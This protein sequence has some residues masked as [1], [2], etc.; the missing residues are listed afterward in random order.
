MD[1][2]AICND[3]HNL[4]PIQYKMDAFNPGNGT[5]YF[6]NMPAHDEFVVE[7]TGDSGSFTLLPWSKDTCPI[8]CYTCDEDN[9]NQP[10]NCTENAVLSDEVTTAV[11]MAIHALHGNSKNPDIMN[12]KEIYQKALSNTYPKYVKGYMSTPRIKGSKKGTEYVICKKKCADETE[13]PLR[14]KEDILNAIGGIKNLK[15]ENFDKEKAMEEL[16]G[17][18][19]SLRDMEKDE[20]GNVSVLSRPIGE[21]LIGLTLLMRKTQDDHKSWR[22]NANYN[23]S[24]MISNLT[25][26]M[27][28]FLNEHSLDGHFFLPYDVNEDPDVVDED[29]ELFIHDMERVYNILT[30]HPKSNLLAIKFYKLTA[31]ENLQGTGLDLSKIFNIRIVDDSMVI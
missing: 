16:K 3:F 7:Y 12:S 14:S 28:N 19:V 13:T 5:V 25:P 26:L 17:L 22:F 6:L 24:N 31:T 9:N 10:K 2:V 15:L 18:C 21:S 27:V 20:K 11:K 8:D 29:K 23:N 30:A 4:I 1:E